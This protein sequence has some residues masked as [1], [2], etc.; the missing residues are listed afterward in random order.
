MTK[1]I[2]DAEARLEELNAK[3]GELTANF[4]RI[5][6]IKESDTLIKEA[7][8][9]KTSGTQYALL[10]ARIENGE[11]SKNWS[12]HRQSAFVKTTWRMLR[13]Q[14]QLMMLRRAS[15]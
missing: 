13:Q 2:K 3:M 1:S 15:T 7:S 14:I 9:V 5:N 12:H 11:K 8:I 6:T 4:D 10:D